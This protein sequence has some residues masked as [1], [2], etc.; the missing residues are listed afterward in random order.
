MTKIGRLSEQITLK[1][2]STG[3]S[4]GIGGNIPGAAV[5]LASNLWAS[6][7]PVPAKLAIRYQGPQNSR[8]Y[9]IVTRAIPELN[10]K[11]SKFWVEWAGKK[12][13]VYSTNDAFNRG[14]D[15]EILVFEVV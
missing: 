6:V 15:L 9:N 10:L 13:T 8:F 12:L 4:D 7:D 1:T 2:I 3:S 14:N 11:D 5:T